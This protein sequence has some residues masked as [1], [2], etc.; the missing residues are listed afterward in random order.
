M[1]PIRKAPLRHEES[2]SPLVVS[3]K[4]PMGDTDPVSPLQPWQD[5]HSAPEDEPPP[6]QPLSAGDARPLMDTSARRV[7]ANVAANV[8]YFI[9]QTAVGIWWTPYLV[10]HLGIAVYGMIPLASQLTSYMAL[11]TVAIQ[12]TVGRFVTV[13]MAR[14]DSDAAGRTFNTAFIASLALFAVLWPVGQWCASVIPH[15]IDVPPG[16]GPDVRWLYGAS[17]TTLLLAVVGAC[18]SAACVVRNRIDLRR[19]IDAS[20]LLARIGFTAALFCL[21]PPARL[22][23]V[24]GATV[25]SALVS[26]TGSLFVWRALTP[27]L[28]VQPSAFDFA[29]LREMLH[30]GTWLMVNQ[31]GAILFLSVDLPIINLVCGAEAGGKYGA[32]LQWSALLR[33]IGG[34]LGGAL[35]PLFLWRYARGDLQ[36][37]SE[38]SRK[39][40]KLLGLAV[41]LPIGLVVGLSRPI[42]SAW[43]G[44]DFAELA[45]LMLLL[46]GH[47]CINIAVTPMFWTQ[48]AM[49][50]VVVPGLVTVAMGL[51][52]V[53][54]ALLLA[55]PLRWGIYG[56]AAA[57][58]IVLTAKNAFFTPLYAAHILQRP[59]W[60]FLAS[61]LPSLVAT[62]LVAGLGMYISVVTDLSTWRRLIEA[63]LVICVLYAP[64]AYFLGLRADERLAVRRALWQR[65]G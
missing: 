15:Y 14:G 58:A 62:A 19:W 1:V 40:T 12:G 22:A 42:L 11:L 55:G 46:T 61:M 43:L 45:P 29:A 21:L 60:Q 8:V 6:G 52:N 57:N 30:M 41:A 25:M 59:R 35:M 36:G 34:V 10:A 18:L 3:G 16:C 49:N 65:A 47:L 4:M 2:F 53:G 37:L 13:H 27:M 48:T 24:A 32:V 54:L 28:R 7:I 50:R 26:L 33:T 23:H 20:E 31:L 64:A 44:T 17:V 56:V 5:D 38:L 9:A 63:G 39:T 51:V